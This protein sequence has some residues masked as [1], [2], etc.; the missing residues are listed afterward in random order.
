MDFDMEG[1]VIYCDIPYEGTQGYSSSFNHDEFW[2]RAKYLSQKN[3]VFVSS[4]EAPEEWECVWKKEKRM[5]LSK[6]KREIRCE[7]LFKLKNCV[8]FKK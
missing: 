4:Y 2:E 8:Q 3:I 1:A 7:K 6:N 5:T